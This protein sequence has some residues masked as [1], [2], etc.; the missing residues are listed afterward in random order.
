MQF[1]ILG[2][3]EIVGADG[4]RHPLRS[5]KIS[6][7]LALLIARSGEVVSVDTLVQELWGDNPPRSALTTLQTYVYQARRMFSNDIDVAPMRNLLVT[8]APGYLLDIEPAEVDA[9]IFD[10]EL[11]RGSQLLRLGQ[12][13]D[14]SAALEGALTLFRG[15][16]C[17]SVTAGEVLASHVTHLEGQR[18]RATELR[19]EAEMKLGRHRELIPELQ[20]LT[21]AYP[22]NEWLHGQLMG[23]LH[24]SG[25]RAEAL[26]V[27]HRLRQVLNE[28]LGLEPTA[29]VQRL[30]RGV[31]EPDGHRVS[32]QDSPDH[33]PAPLRIRPQ[34]APVAME[35]APLADY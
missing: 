22:L 2:A 14:A 32:D 26:Q 18:M 25:R 21:V 7:V 34:R 9:R 1:N 10:R 11:L 13:E 15:S 3:L 5:S 17:A 6:Q 23:A 4:R 29:Q 35:S 31:L 19:I 27:F 16:P 8:R 24:R 20:A 30:H 33:R 28:Q 12:L